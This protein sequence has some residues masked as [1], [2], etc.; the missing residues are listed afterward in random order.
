MA[1]QRLSKLQKFILKECYLNPE[2]ETD[3]LPWWKCKNLWESE[4]IELL[5]YSMTRKGIFNR[6]HN[7]NGDYNKIQVSLSRSLR[8]LIIKG[9]IEEL[10]FEEGEVYIKVLENRIKYLQEI[11]N[12]PDLFRKKLEQKKELYLLYLQTIGTISNNPKFK[13]NEIKESPTENSLI[14]EL[15]EE[16]E[17]LKTKGANHKNY[18]IEAISLSD[19]GIEQAKGLLNVK[20]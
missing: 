3:Y 14:K 9:L 7:G 20:S 16:I 13:I 4:K 10:Y 11:L 15:K 2:K 1:N 19:K 18:I 12:N 17:L 5:E 8:N 6:L